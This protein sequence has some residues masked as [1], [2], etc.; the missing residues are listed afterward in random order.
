M[1]RIKLSYKHILLVPV[2]LG[3]ILLAWSLIPMIYN[4]MR[5]PAPMLR[6]HVLRHTPIGMGMEEVI[7]VIENNG[8]WGSPAIN[9]ESGFAHPRG[10]IPGEWPVDGLLTKASIIGYKSIRTS[11]ERY[12]L[13]NIMGS[14]MPVSTRIFWGFDEDG[15]LIEVYVEKSLV[16]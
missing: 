7:E 8:R 1:K 6:N 14:S 12:N 5:R 15:K 13:W 10:I 3:G 4:P 16:F 9:R 2:L 11:A